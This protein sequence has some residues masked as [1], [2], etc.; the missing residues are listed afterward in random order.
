MFLSAFSNFIEADFRV[1]DF[2]ISGIEFAQKCFSFDNSSVIKDINTFIDSI[3][4]PVD[5]FAMVHSFEHLYDPDVTLSNIKK[6]LTTEGLLYIEVP[7][8]LAT[9][10]DDPTHIYMYSSE[11][12][13]TIVEA[14]GFKILSKTYSDI[15]RGAFDGYY[16]S[17]KQN[18]CVLAANI[19]ERKKFKFL[20][21]IG[22]TNPTKEI[23]NGHR[24]VMQENALFNIKKGFRLF[25]KSLLK[26]FYSIIVRG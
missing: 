8:A 19:V 21:P 18:I 14:N 25:C 1:S 3:T 22:G 15:P 6:K 12:L 26:L 16:A 5:M 10:L 11:T 24:A 2:N 20:P 4:E 7:N 17:E 13:Q 9:P 23:Q